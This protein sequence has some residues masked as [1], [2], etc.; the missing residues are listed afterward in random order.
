MRF[1]ATC[2]CLLS[3]ATQLSPADGGAGGG[4]GGG[5]GGAGGAGGTLPIATPADRDRLWGTLTKAQQA[6]ITAASAKVAA[7]MPDVDAAFAKAELLSA[8][9]AIGP[10]NRASALE[11]LATRLEDS[12]HPDDHDALTMDDLA[13]GDK[14]AREAS[15]PISDLEHG[16]VETA[17]RAWRKLLA[18]GPDA[19]APVL[20]RV[21][22]LPPDSVAAMRLR[23]VAGE[24]AQF[25]G[26]Q[27]I[28]KALE[29]AQ[30]AIATLPPAARSTAIWVLSRD[31]CEAGDHGAYVG[32][33]LCYWSF[34]MK[35]HTYGS[36][37]VS[38]EYG[39]AGSGFQVQMYGGQDNQIVDLGT[40]LQLPGSWTD[41]LA[42]TGALAGEIRATAVVGHRYAERLHEPKVDSWVLFT[43]LA[44]DRDWC[45]I[46]VLDPNE[47]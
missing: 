12:D 34:P 41:A 31:A 8:L 17:D 33:A 6:L 7:E 14:V 11:Q 24:L 37:P 26:H 30:K 40:R 2:A 42:T 23:L 43:V 29:G 46:R 22:Q 18:I 10:G 20:A 28:L 35:K 13:R 21:Q 3:L 19:R 32:Q 47:R 16:D 1:L 39:N 25:S 44:M 4:G 36:D 27:R 38:L 45:V 9:L 5:A 15:V